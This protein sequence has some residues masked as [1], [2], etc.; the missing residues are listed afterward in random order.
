MF[1]L[2]GTCNYF[3]IQNATVKLEFLQVELFLFTKVYIS[4]SSWMKWNQK[5]QEFDWLQLHVGL[6]RK[7]FTVTWFCNLFPFRQIKNW[8]LFFIWYI[9][10]LYLDNIEILIS[11]NYF[12]PHYVYM[13]FHSCIV[14]QKYSSGWINI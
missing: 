9:I 11:A 2:R 1:I 13:F 4:S 7:K 5:F 14:Y 10:H 3:L 12:C 8:N 6:P